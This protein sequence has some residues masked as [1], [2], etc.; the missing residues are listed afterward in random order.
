MG[1]KI[2]MQ[3]IK[4]TFFSLLVLACSIGE[5][6]AQ[7]LDDILFEPAHNGKVA[8][9]IKL[10]GPVELLQYFPDK[11]G[12][13]LEIFFK[14]LVDSSSTND[15]WQ[16]Y[17]ART[18]PSSDLIPSFVV[19]ARDL[20]TQPKLVIDFSRPAE[21]SVRIGKSKRS[22]VIYI[23]TDK[24]KANSGKTEPVKEL[25][26][27][28]N[29]ASAPQAPIIVTEKVASA[30][31]IAAIPVAAPA[32]A[33]AP[34]PTITPV[35]V[36][37]LVAAASVPAVAPTPAITSVPV[38]KI[39]AAAS[40]PAVAP[41]PAAA[42]IPVVDPFP[43]TKIAATASVPTVAPIP[44][45]PE[46]P[47][48]AETSSADQIKATNIQAEALMV[49]GRDAIKANQYGMAIDSF[50]KL[51]LLPP[52]KY[53]QE[54]QELIGVARE[55]AGQKF[56]AQREYETYLKL[57]TSGEGVARV[58]ARLAKLSAEQ[59]VQAAQHVQDVSQAA[60]SSDKNKFQ[61]ISSGSVSV[62]Y[63]NGVNQTVVAGATAQ[64]GPV[65]DQSMLITNVSA[66]L[67]SRNDRY[68]NR[69]VFQDTYNKNF[70]PT[71]LS[72]FNPNP[73]RLGAAYYE[74]KDKVIDFSS[75]IGRQSPSGG[76]VM[77]RFDGISAGYGITPNW[78]ITS[79]AGQ[80]SDYAPGSK[81]TF[82]SVGLGLKNGAHWGGSVYYVSQKTNGVIDRSAVGA[83]MRYFDVNKNAFSMVDYDTFF[84]VLN[85][86]L[87]QG[88][89]NGASGTTYN[90]NLDHRRSPSISLS[91]ALIGSPSTMQYLLT[92][93]K[94]VESPVGSGNF[95]NV[96]GGGFTIDDL[97]ALAILRTGHFR[98]GLAG[99]KHTDKRNMASRGGHKHFQIIRFAGKRNQCTRFS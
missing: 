6:S 11:Q 15:P 51:L 89:I 80:L 67:R 48:A 65:T 55:G 10:N 4:T 25:P 29:G 84:N 23:T 8:A 61:T 66:S 7:L 20:L 21:Y 93:S 83:E 71:Q 45:V 76:G 81:P 43:E 70:L 73:N 46:A 91:N 33:V 60:S 69:L 41:T 52:N 13:H 62:N 18:S 27:A 36:P 94:L 3:K 31:V 44:V 98:F 78:Q 97:K 34:T 9:I 90:F 59:P 56:R 99:C 17:E 26:V 88:S 53:S 79:A 28:K 87:L 96:G 74:F 39:V 35:P 68:D 95:V 64:A 22:F 30:S 58:K 16:G 85:M 5:A 57:Y 82:Y 40:V 1:I 2:N 77:G 50:N 72:A 19:S 12:Q 86:A 75:R 24:V 63:Y 54:A 49:K 38:P 42:P 47:V 92:P 14:I 37:K 32:P